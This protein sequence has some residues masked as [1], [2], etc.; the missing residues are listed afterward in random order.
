M[1]ECKFY[2]IKMKTQNENKK[3]KE[4]WKIKIKIKKWTE[5]EDLSAEQLSLVSDL[6]HIKFSWK[7]WNKIRWSELFLCGVLLK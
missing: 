7:K 3:K 6:I 2:I 4:K 5:K 1:H